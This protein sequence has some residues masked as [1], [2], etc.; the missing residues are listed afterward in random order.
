MVEASNS[1]GR[2]VAQASKDDDSA[3][4]D[5]KRVRGVQRS[6][7]SSGVRV[8]VWFVGGDR[9]RATAIRVIPVL[10]RDI[11]IPV[12]VRRLSV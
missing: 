2:D 3:G 11:H 10:L 12:R 6:V 7:D 9:S 5:L 4:V 8:S 1:S